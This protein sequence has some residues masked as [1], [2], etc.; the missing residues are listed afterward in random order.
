M[1][2]RN[3]NYVLSKNF[4]VSFKTKKD[5]NNHIFICAQKNEILVVDIRLPL[6]KSTSNI[7]ECKKD[8]EITCMCPFKKNFMEEKY[9][10]YFLVGGIKNKR[11]VEVYLYTVLNSDEKYN[12]CTSIEFLKTVVYEKKE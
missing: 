9:C 3:N 6:N 10:P 8:L 7:F 11:I 1:K 5:S 4:I 2:E 12:N